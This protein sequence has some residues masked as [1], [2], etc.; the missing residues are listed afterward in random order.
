MMTDSGWDTKPE[1][2]LPE[3]T[4]G[5]N[6][7]DE[8]GANGGT[9]GRLGQARGSIR[10][11]LSTSLSRLRR[12]RPRELRSCGWVL[13]MVVLLIVVWAISVGS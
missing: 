6:Q 11:I 5:E 9:P 10:Q 4:S 8:S 13:L 12:Q 3:G 7:T 2:S 1:W